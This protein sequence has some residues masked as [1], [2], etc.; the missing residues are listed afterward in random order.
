MMALAWPLMATSRNMSSFGACQA[1][2]EF[3]QRGFGY[4]QAP[5]TNRQINCAR[6]KGVW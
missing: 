1:E 6:G 4:L 2:R 3:G 5:F